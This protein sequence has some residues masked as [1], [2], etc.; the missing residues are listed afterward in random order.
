MCCRM[1]LNSKGDECFLK[2][3]TFRYIQSLTISKDYNF[4]SSHTFLVFNSPFCTYSRVVYGRSANKL[5]CAYAIF[6]RD[7]LTLY[8]VYNVSIQQAKRNKNKKK[9]EDLLMRIKYILI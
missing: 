9:I 3:N 7:K 5:R 8:I 1:T 2:K 6:K 4:T